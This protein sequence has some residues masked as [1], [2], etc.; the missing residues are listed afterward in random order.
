MSQLTPEQLT[1]SCHPTSCFKFVC[2]DLRYLY[3][4]E[5]YNLSVLD[6]LISLPDQLLHALEQ[7]V[8]LVEHLM[9][10]TEQLRKYARVVI[11][12]SRTVCKCSVAKLY[13]C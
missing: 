5:P 6:T 1:I 7:L 12:C 2:T 10:D 4:T 11:E 9:S 13:S 3:L 8:S